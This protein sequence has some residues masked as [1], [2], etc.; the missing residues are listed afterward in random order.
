MTLQNTRTSKKGYKGGK[1]KTVY[2][3]LGVWKEKEYG[4]IHITIPKE[5]YFHTT[6][7]NQTGSIRCHK[8]LYLK[9]RKLLKK[10]HCW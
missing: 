2:A 7:N 5:K 10:Y 3:T 4:H 8:N 9:L 1:G 6:I